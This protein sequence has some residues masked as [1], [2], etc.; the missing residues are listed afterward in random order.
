VD[1]TRD[2]LKKNG[3]ITLENIKT[4]KGRSRPA[5]YLVLREQSLNYLNIKQH[6]GKGSFKHQLYCHLIK[7]KLEKEGWVAKI[8]SAV[9]PSTKLIDVVAEKDKAIV[10]YEVTLH[11]DN[12]QENIEKDFEAINKLVIVVEK[13]DFGQA[14]EEIQKCKTT[15]EPNAHLDIKLVEDFFFEKKSNFSSGNAN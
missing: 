10:G 1:K 4:T 3:Y 7:R 6:L 12:L 8:E 14:V 2:W 9:Y 5:C 13:S 11:F 15:L